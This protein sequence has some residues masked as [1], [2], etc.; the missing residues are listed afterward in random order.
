MK[1]FLI[2]VEVGCV[3]L[4]FELIWNFILLLFGIVFEDSES[5]FVILNCLE[6]FRRVIS[7]ISTFGM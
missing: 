7:V 5:V 6:C 2:V 1:G 3:K 4:M